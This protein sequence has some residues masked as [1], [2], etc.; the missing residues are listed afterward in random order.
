MIGAKHEASEAVAADEDAPDGASAYPRPLVAWTSAGLM[1]L[2]FALAY[3]DRQVISLMVGQIS[4]EFGIGDFQ[5]SLLQG[6]AFAILFAVCGLPLGLAVDRWPR[7]YIIFA[8]VL[9]WSIAAT[10]CG[11]SRSYGEMLVARIAVGVGEAALAPACYSLMAALFPRRQLTFALGVFM[12][13]AL[14]GAEGSLAI[15]GT[16][17]QLARNGV[18]L[19]L[20]GHVPAWRFA[21]IATG[22]PGIALAFLALLIHEPPRERP[23]AT[24]R[25]W[26]EAFAFVATRKRFFA[27]QFF[28]FALLMALAGARGAWTPTF[29][30]RTYGWSVAQVSYALASYGFVTGTFALLAS[31]RVV[32]WLFQRG[33]S[34]AHYRYCVVGGAVVAVFGVLAHLSPTADGYFAAIFLPLLVLNYGAIGASAVQIVTPPHLRGRISALYL[35]VISLVGISLGPAIVGALTEFVFRDPKSLGLAMALTFG[36]LGVVVCGLF[37]FGA[38][39]MRDAVMRN[40]GAAP[41]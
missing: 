9:V 35:M 2:M 24:Q 19:P 11:L 20:L 23:S 16:V 26:G 41:G 22:L 17:L 37:L 27:V 14:L 40:R 30:M 15:G 25:G 6:F 28:G 33:M 5:I 32:D 34:D 29:F 31:G 13:G 4:A 12:V 10:S 8:G 7:R 38:A 36:C 39:G 3:M 1:T 21:F 18:D